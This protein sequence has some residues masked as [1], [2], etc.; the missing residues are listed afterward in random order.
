MPKVKTRKAKVYKIKTHSGAKKRFHIT[1]K[2][3]VM[4]SHAY[5]SHIL[6]KKPANKK[7]KLRK[8]TVADSTNAKRIIKLIPYK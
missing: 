7:R 6:T 1:G 4:R 3:K 5:M 2:G 8:G